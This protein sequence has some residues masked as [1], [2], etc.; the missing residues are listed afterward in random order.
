MNAKNLG[1]ARAT[2]LPS[3]EWEARLAL[4]YASTERGVRLVKSEHCGPLYVQKP[5]Y[6]EGK[7]LPHTYILHPPGGLVSG[8]TLTISVDIADDAGALFTTPGAGRVYRARLDNRLQKQH[9]TLNVGTNSSVEW[10]P[11]ETILYPR[12]HGQLSTRINLEANARVVA[13][14]VCC[15]GL[16][17]SDQHFTEGS[18]TQRFEIYQH[19]KLQLFD[20]LPLNAKCRDFL[21]GAAGLAGN[22]VVGFMVAGTFEQ[23]PEALLNRM[24]TAITGSKHLF[25]ISYVN[26]FVVARYLGHSAE[27]A[28]L[29]MG[30]C[31]RLLRPELL[32]R[33]AC[34]PR[35]WLC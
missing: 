23:A 4:T 26:G 7:H 2:V 34:P 35:I 31:W 22:S 30:L 3:S 16:P 29:L 1:L 33:E 15:L 28:R 5:F 32:R 24:R 17:A 12:A 14:D 27:Q 19:G 20:R 9:V 6:P 10:L 18:L 11:L 25:G 21:N 8:D 13:W